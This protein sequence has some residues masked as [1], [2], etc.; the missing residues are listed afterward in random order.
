MIRKQ[1]VDF[2]DDRDLTD[3]KFALILGCSP[4]LISGLRTGEKNLSFRN[5]L[6]TSILMQ[7][8]DS[9]HLMSKWCLDLNTTEG[10]KQ[11]FEYAYISRNKELVER[12]LDTYANESGVINECY[13]IYNILYEYNMKY[14]IKTDQ[15]VVKASELKVKDKT[16]QI[17]VDIIKACGMYYRKQ[18]LL[19]LEYADHIQ[20]AVSSLSDK[21]ELFFKECFNLRLSEIYTPA[22]FHLNQMNLCRIHANRLISSEICAKMVSDGYYYMGMTYLLED[23]EKCINCLQKGYDLLKS[24]DEILSA[25]ALS[26]LNFALSFL[27]K[28]LAPG[29]QDEYIV[30]FNKI[31]NNIKLSDGEIALLFQDGL[32]TYKKYY[33]AVYENTIESLRDVFMEF[34]GAKNYFFASVVFKDISSISKDFGLIEGLLKLNLDN[35][36]VGRLEK[37]VS[38]CFS[39]FSSLSLA[40]S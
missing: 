36:G 35:E 13:Q 10:I 24:E 21:R 28:P 33:K 23:K 6:K 37:N 29:E 7:G 9:R 32:S 3:K 20:Q 16:L 19:M 14:S 22:L 25:Q 17:L 8:R 5:M 2:I 34:L 4:Q 1:I 30:T 39:D 11:A 12:L 38:M 27:K 40:C 18:Y 15:L 26:N 31:K